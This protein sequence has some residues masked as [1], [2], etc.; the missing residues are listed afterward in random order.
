MNIPDSAD[1]N[2]FLG[3]E[4]PAPE[5]K[6]VQPTAAPAPAN[7]AVPAGVSSIAPTPRPEHIQNT[8]AV[9]AKPLDASAVTNQPL[10]YG[11]PAANQ[12]TEQQRTQIQL[13]QTG[14]RIAQ[15]LNLL[16][17]HLSE[18]KFVEIAH[19]MES[20]PISQ[21]IQQEMAETAIAS[22]KGI[23]FAVKGHLAHPEVPVA[24]F[25]ND[26]MLLIGN[27]KYGQRPQ[28]GLAGLE[29]QFASLEQHYGL[30]KLQLPTAP[31]S[32]T[33]VPLEGLSH[34]KHVPGPANNNIMAHTA[35]L[36]GKIAQVPQVAAQV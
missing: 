18:Q 25:V 36:Q 28:N 21:H 35:E 4:P 11:I 20:H 31:V 1:T 19:A 9:G 33:S 15:E 34:A 10:S 29:Q 2:D 22:M 27:F 5:P 8:G 23:V 24:A 13:M 16:S 6:P 32:A 14:Q 17:T 26:A 12:L 3:F 7:Q 30:D